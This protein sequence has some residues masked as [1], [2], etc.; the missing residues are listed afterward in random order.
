MVR[1]PKIQQA[2]K[3]RARKLQNASP[4]MMQS[5]YLSGPDYA[6]GN[7]VTGKSV[8]QQLIIQGNF[9]IGWA[10]YV[11]SIPEDT[12]KELGYKF[13]LTIP[14]MPDVQGRLRHTNEAMLEFFKESDPQSVSQLMQVQKKNPSV[15]TSTFDEVYLKNMKRWY[16]QGYMDPKTNQVITGKTILQQCIATKKYAKAFVTYMQTLDAPTIES[17]GFAMRT[18]LSTNCRL[19]GMDAKDMKLESLLKAL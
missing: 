2:P 17:M 4:E 10:K 8:V 16:H 12:W 9:R 11:K 14:G 5:W 18:S 6:T 15:E 13:P 1:I 3:L 19:L 7:G